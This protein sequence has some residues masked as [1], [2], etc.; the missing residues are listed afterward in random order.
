MQV[1][2]DV[3]GHDLFTSLAQ[4]EVLWKNEMEIVEV[5]KTAIAKMEIATEA[6]NKYENIIHSMGA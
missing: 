2:A 5:M 6:M 1:K 3:G 4:L